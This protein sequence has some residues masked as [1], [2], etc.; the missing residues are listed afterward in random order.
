MLFRKE[1]GAQEGKQHPYGHKQVFVAHLMT[2]QYGSRYNEE[3]EAECG[4]GKRKQLMAYEVQDL[5]GEKLE[6]AHD[7]YRDFQ[8]HRDL[9]GNGGKGYQPHKHNEI[10]TLEQLVEN[11]P[12]ASGLAVELQFGLVGQ[13]PEHLVRP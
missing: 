4:G 11:Q 2:A 10:Y 9:P 3:Q 1:T 6:K 8:C 13:L 7:K 5:G 12:F